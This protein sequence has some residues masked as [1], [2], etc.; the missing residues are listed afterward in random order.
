MER[1]IAP[2]GKLLCL[3]KIYYFVYYIL[4]DYLKFLA[5]CL[6]AH[7]FTKNVENIPIKYKTIISLSYDDILTAQKY[8]RLFSFYIIIF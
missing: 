2:K 4:G 5:V 1:L 7:L 8:I 6:L 3:H